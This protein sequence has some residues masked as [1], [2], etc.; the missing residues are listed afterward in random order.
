MDVRIGLPSL[1]TRFPRYTT[2]EMASPAAAGRAYSLHLSEESGYNLNKPGDDS[3]SLTIDA[4]TLHSVH[5]LDRTS[6]AFWQVCLFAV[7]LRQLPGLAFP[8]IVFLPLP[9]SVLHHL[10]LKS[11]K[12]CRGLRLPDVPNPLFP[13]LPPLLASNQKNQ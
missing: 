12:G 6:S 8:L 4:D 9:R 2:F 13:F 5:T 10:L 11:L 3:C 7:G 1:S